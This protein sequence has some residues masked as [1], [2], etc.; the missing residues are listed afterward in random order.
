M[1]NALNVT[2]AKPGWVEKLNKL[3]SYVL[4]PLMSVTF[5]CFNTVINKWTGERMETV[6]NL[7]ALAILGVVFC[8]LIYAPKVTLLPWIKQNAL[9]FVYFAARAISL[10][11]SGFDY[12]VIRTIFFEVFFLIGICSFT[13]QGAKKIYIDVFICL[14]LAASA[15]SLVIYHY[16]LG[17]NEQFIGW[18]SAH[19]YYDTYPIALVF[20]NPNTAGIMAGFSIVLAIVLFGNKNYNKW[21]MG[22][23]GIYNVYALV[24]FGCRSSD[25]GVLVVIAA[26]LSVKAL[27]KFKKNTL[28]FVTLIAMTATLIP[29]YSIVNHYP[30]LELAPIEIKLD[31]LSTGRYLIWEEC[32][33]IQK[34][35]PV[36]GHGNLKL[37]QDA[38]GAFARTLDNSY[39][40][41]YY[42][43]A[44]LGP[45]N[46][47]IGM[48]SG[49]GWVGFLL[50][51][52]ILLQRLKRAK[53]LANGRWYLM[54]VFIFTINCFESLFI[55]NRFFACFY[56]FLILETDM[57]ESRAE[58]NALEQDCK[59]VQQ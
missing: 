53:H 38:R 8:N 1:E 12:S 28:A 51:T 22:L 7:L 2:A 46:G 26:A 27:P 44:E 49:T 36:F 31:N 43:A 20:S 32:I 24:M 55:L 50:F 3:S 10:W 48:I 11:Q 4:M 21:F 58:N 56:M 5:I 39:Y 25:V 34:Q 54:L 16:S 45:H 52:A 29:I 30:G 37:E 57:D 17:A 6:Q 35:S 13:V 23:F 59:E 18:L 14:E 19:T 41:R 15:L 33:E 9:V 42:K 47:Y 40:W